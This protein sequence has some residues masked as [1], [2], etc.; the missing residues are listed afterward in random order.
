M[1]A[2]ADCLAFPER[3]SSAPCLSFEAHSIRND[4]RTTGVRRSTII[5][6][7]AKFIAP[8]QISYDEAK[9]IARNAPSTN[10]VVGNGLS[11]AAWEK[12]RGD[13]IIEQARKV[14]ANNPCLSVLDYQNFETI[15][16]FLQTTS[17]V[18]QLVP[19]ASQAIKDQIS[20]L[21]DAT[22]RTF[23]GTLCD[24]HPAR[25]TE[26]SKHCG[27]LIGAFDQ[28]FTLNYDVLLYRSIFQSNG[29]ARLQPG[30]TKEHPE[31]NAFD[32]DS[33]PGKSHTMFF[34]HGCLA[35]YADLGAGQEYMLTFWR[36]RKPL[37]M[38]ARK[39]IAANKFPT[40]V[41]GGTWQEKMKIIARSKYLR[42]CYDTL[43]KVDGTVMILGCSLA[44]ND[45]HI[46]AQIGESKAKTIL[47]GMFERTDSTE[48]RE[49][50]GRAFRHFGHKDLYLFESPNANELWS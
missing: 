23:I 29:Q 14:V 20:K 18:L 6:P 13:K 9:K 50:C 4:R 48:W 45:T 5:I 38:Q 11:I 40:F 49:K 7:M 37:V 21:A 22:R 2:Q 36:K 32:Y 8:T 27:G 3:T 39:L 17:Q 16:G 10:L 46:W 12:F 24:I 30:F 33:Q 28:V 43:R 26:F 47:V 15:D 1:W 25:Q 44:D 42:I 35:L 41:C 34:L 19:E 31:G